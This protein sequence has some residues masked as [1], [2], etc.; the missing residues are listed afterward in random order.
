MH[1]QVCKN[2]ESIGRSDSGFINRTML[3][4]ASTLPHLV[5]AVACQPP[6][7]TLLISSLTQKNAYGETAAGSSR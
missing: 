3:Y 6:I 7:V 2:A 1:S 5:L 4:L